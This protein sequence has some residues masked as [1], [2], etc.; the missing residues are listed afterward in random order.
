MNLDKYR[1]PFATV[2]AIVALLVASPALSRVLVYPRTDFFTEMW[3]LGPNHKAEGYPF[4]VTRAQPYKGY[5]GLANHL[6]YAAYYVVEVKFRNDTQSKPSSFGPLSNQTPSTLPSLYNISAF[7]ADQD[8]WELPLN[9]SFN[10]A[11][12]T[13]SSLQMNSL[14]LNGALLGISNCTIAWDSQ[15]NGFYGYLFFEA[16]I[17]N[18]TVSSFSYHERFVSLRLNMTL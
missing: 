1:V 3:L 15:R 14:T 13:A 9:F 5:L 11:S 12:T 16:W 6:G 2:V 4:D 17:Y 18:E 10:Y 7:V 8:T